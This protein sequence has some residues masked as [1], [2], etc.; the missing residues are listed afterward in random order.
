MKQV[1][2][3]TIP[4]LSSSE[5]MVGDYHHSTHCRPKTKRYKQT[6]PQQIHSTEDM[7]TASII[8]WKHT[9]IQRNIK[10]PEYSMEHSVSR[11]SNLLMIQMTG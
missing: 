4:T 3:Y 6:M 5:M 8:L 7:Q 10:L 9:P 1:V 2:K 11:F